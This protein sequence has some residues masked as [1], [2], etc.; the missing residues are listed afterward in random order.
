M[1]IIRWDTHFIVVDASTRDYHFSEKSTSD[2]VSGFDVYHIKPQYVLNPR[3]L[4]ET[5]T[6]GYCRVRND[7]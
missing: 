1:A 6:F 4:Q 3:R 2:T 7:H 5:T